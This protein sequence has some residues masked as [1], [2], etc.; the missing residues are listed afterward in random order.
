MSVRNR[1]KVIEDRTGAGGKLLVVPIRD[2]DD[3]EKVNSAARQALGVTDEQ[4]GLT[5]NVVRFSD[6]PVGK[7]YLHP[8]NR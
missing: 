5:V 1:I 6:L 8:T 4:I 7:A 2:G 3:A